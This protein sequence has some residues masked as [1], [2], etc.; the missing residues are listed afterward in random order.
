MPL[1]SPGETQFIS[2][3]TRKLGREVGDADARSKKKSCRVCDALS[4][5]LERRRG[6]EKDMSDI[7]VK[8]RQ[9]KRAERERE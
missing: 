9:N 7:G 4:P 1:A 2:T 8:T 3:H 6:N 5:T